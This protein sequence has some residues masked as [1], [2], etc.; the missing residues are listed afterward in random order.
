[1]LQYYRPPRAIRAFS[2][3]DV[4]GDSP[5]STADEAAAVLLLRDRDAR[6]RTLLHVAAAEGNTRMALAL[7]PTATDLAA[8]DAD[9]NTSAHL[10]AAGTSPRVA[11]LFLVSGYDSVA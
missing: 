2:D 11:R 3:K 4:A 8:R 7:R 5:A 6:F 10:A 9:G 1:M